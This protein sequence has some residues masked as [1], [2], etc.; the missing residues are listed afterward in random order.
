MSTDIKDQTD[1]ASK[2]EALS[3][4]SIDDLRILWRKLY[5]AHPPPM[6]GRDLL[7]LAIAWK[8]QAQALG[9]LS[10]VVKRRI[11]AIEAKGGI[12]KKRAVQP[13]PGARLMRAWQGKT[14]TVLVLDDGFEWQGKRHASLSAIARRITGTRWSGPRFFGL[15]KPARE[16]VNG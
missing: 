6:I 5:Q 9:G 15:D 3:E 4:T 1:L 16:T 8:L 10:S 2:L 12:R 7:S 11:A 13:K 14:H